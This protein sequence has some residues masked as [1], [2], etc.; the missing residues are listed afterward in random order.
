MT[1]HRSALS[2]LVLV[3]VAA[4]TAH[5]EDAYYEVRG[6]DLKFTDGTWPAPDEHAPWPWMARDRLMS[7]RAVLADGEAH[8]RQPDLVNRARDGQVQFDLVLVARVPE[9][10]DIAGRLFIPLRATPGGKV[11]VRML[12]FRH[13]AAAARRVARE[14]FL[15]ARMDHYESLL[16]QQLPGGAWFRYRAEQDADAIGKQR[17]PRQDR[18]ARRNAFTAD[19]TYDLFTGGRAVSENLALDRGLILGTNMAGPD[20]DIST[21]PGIT[22]KGFD[23]K[24]LI[25]DAKPELDPLASLIP[26][27]QH[28]I[29]FPGFQAMRQ[30]SDEADTFGTDAL[31]FAEPRSEDSGVKGRYQKQL[32]LPMT[33][34]GRIVGPQVIE[35]IAVTG[36]DP[37][38]RVGS[39]VAVIF[40]AKD[41]GGLRNAL[42]A[43]LLLA[44]RGADVRAVDGKASDVPYTGVVADDRSVCAYQATLGNAVVVT[45]SLTQLERI[46]AVH[47]KDVPSLA[48][49]EEYVFFR[50]RYK[51][52][53]SDEACLIVLSDATIRRWC[54]PQWRIADS[55][56]T[57]IAAAMADVQA[58][59][60]GSIALGTAVP[61]PLES[62]LLPGERL[63]L[64]K[65]GV[66]SDKYGTLE[67]M[68]PIL[69]LGITTATPSEKAGY[70]RWRT[71]YQDN[72]RKFFDPI[73]LR[74]GNSNQRL[75]LD[76]TVMPLIA[77]TEYRTLVNFTKNG[78]LLATSG[79]PHDALLQGVFAIDRQSAEFKEVD[80]FVTG[81]L[82]HNIDA[83]IGE[84]ISLYVDDDDA[85]FVRL[86][87]VL[88]ERKQHGDEWSEV[89]VDLPLAVRIDCRD[90]V[91]LSQFLIAARGLTGDWTDIEPVRHNG[92]AY[93]KLSRNAKSRGFIKAD[94]KLYYV[95]L[96]DGWTISFNEDVIKRVIDRHVD[97]GER[98]NERP[99]AGRNFAARGERR[100]LDVLQAAGVEHH[101]AKVQAQSWSNIPILNEWRRLHPDRDPVAVH[102]RLWST[103]LLCPAGGKYVWN[104]EHQ[105]MESTATGHPG[106]PKAPADVRIRS[107]DPFR[108]GDFGLD[109]EH[110]GLRARVTLHKAK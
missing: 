90:V 104:G 65:S 70:E 71:S 82:N 98:K 78:R 96:P 10:K 30:L 26:E 46:I 12:S 9:G 97:G 38:L 2:L 91:R 86:A 50:E 40:E 22:V 110:D 54:S 14:E 17:E 66:R 52:G 58:R 108:A 41:L 63:T 11:D 105:T 74:V 75:S 62:P 61:Q 36:S 37:Y 55:R 51:R 3:L 15:R 56:R 43:Q 99:W 73:A 19:H 25:K 34:M 7:P 84:S 60:A 92:R 8:V 42:S 77:G 101:V 5:G 69:E 83:W 85:Y 32:C 31:N 76:L 18:W 95:A 102:Q 81:A 49:L 23:W 80:K 28:A 57:R 106:A 100:M 88:A 53:E 44:R 35:S 68:T 103:H 39:D 29:F 107:L 94:V 89:L 1:R 16:N 109:F 67:F 13:P 45:N 33:V 20:V 87:R 64:T 21:I 59:H 4:T 24:P 93:M 48:S 6:A 27:D 72:W 47:R 79:D